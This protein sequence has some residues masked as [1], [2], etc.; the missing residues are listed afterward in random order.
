MHFPTALDYEIFIGQRTKIV[1]NRQCNDANSKLN[2]R[3]FNKKGS[4][5]IKKFQ[6]Y[7]KGKK[8]SNEYY[9]EA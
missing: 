1:A 9:S 2:A 4:V 7:K 6:D 3:F 8:A 5:S